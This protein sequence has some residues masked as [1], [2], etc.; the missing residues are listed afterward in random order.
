MYIKFCPYIP[1]I[2]ESGISNGLPT[3]AVQLFYSTSYI[4]GMIAPHAYQSFNSILAIVGIVG[5]HGLRIETHHRSQPNKSNVVLYNPLL[6]K[7][8]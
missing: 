6:Y 2:N 5:R 1:F 4:Y 7:S 8:C 3:V